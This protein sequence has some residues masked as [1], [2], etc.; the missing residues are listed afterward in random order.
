[1]IATV[2]QVV[3]PAV[4]RANNALV[5][6]PGHV[7]R[8]VCPAPLGSHPYG[9][10]NSGVDGVDHYV[11]DGPFMS[12]VR[13][14]AAKP[15]T[16]RTWID[17]W[18]LGVPSHDAY[19]AKLGGDRRRELIAAAGETAAPPPWAGQ[20][21]AVERQIL[22]ASRQITGRVLDG[23]FDAILAGVGLA[24]LASWVSAESVKAADGTV[25]LMAEIG[26]YG[27]TPQAGDPFIFSHRNLPTSTMLTDVMTTLGALVSGPGTRSLGVLGAGEVDSDGNTGSTYSGNGQYLVGSGGANDIATGAD[28]VVLTVSHQ[29]LVP[30]VRYVTCPGDRVS[31][32]VSSRG[33]FERDAGQWVLRSWIAP[34]GEDLRTA[35]AGMRADSPW[36]FSV[37]RDAAPEP[38]PAAGDLALLRSFD[39]GRVFLRP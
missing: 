22:A 7:V 29:R 30:A 13:A 38:E 10:F 5:K 4:I 21:S 37:A 27:Y 1:V 18:I 31:S 6:V 8:A 34:D 20:A 36:P 25:A 3:D 39:P 35:V 19:L 14:A 15:D 2:E 17:E 24:N 23:G 16:F 12:E 33:V 28:E 11:D 26:M 32:I 9:L